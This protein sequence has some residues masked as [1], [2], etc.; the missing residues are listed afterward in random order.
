VTLAKNVALF[1]SAEVWRLVLAKIFIGYW[2]LV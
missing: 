1:N 2:Y